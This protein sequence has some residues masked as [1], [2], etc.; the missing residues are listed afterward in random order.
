MTMAFCFGSTPEVAAFM[1]AYRLANLFRRLIGEG[2]LQS[3][4][5]PY[6]ESFQEEGSQRAVYFY[7]DTAA[8]LLLLLLM[9]VSILMGVFWGMRY[10]LTNEWGEI[11]SLAMWMAPSLI[12]ISLCSL[13]TACLNC[14]KSYFAPAVAPVF[15]NLAWIAVALAGVNLPIRNAIR[16]LAF[17]VTF[18]MAAQWIV[19]AV[20]VR[21]YISLPWSEW[22]RPQIFSA[23][24]KQL[25]RPLFLGL[26][27]VGASQI[28]GLL[29]AIFSR[30][31]DPSG[32]AF[33]W[34]AIRIQQ[35]PLAL[36]GIALA[37]ALLPSLS[38]AIQSGARE[39]YKALLVQGMRHSA[40]LMIP[41]SF[42]LF[43]LAGPGLNLL[44]GR[45][46]FLSADVRETLYCLWGYGIGLL[47]SVFILLLAT[48][49]YAKRSYGAPALAALAAMVLNGILNAIMVFYLH[50]GA[51]SIALATSVASWVNCM[52][53][54]WQLSNQIG[55]IFTSDFWISCRRLCF[56]GGFAACLALIVGAYCGDVTLYWEIPFTRNFGSQLSQFAIMGS[57]F[58]GSFVVV[59]RLMRIKDFFD[60]VR[61]RDKIREPSP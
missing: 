14:K 10:F 26:V 7:R 41:A 12:F 46:G 32:P 17:G 52:I 5:I 6:F 15:F 34:Y 36:F 50:W 51:V 21:K 8:S 20:Q 30:L 33:L 11:A 48:G 57:V 42:G 27:G 23:E 38:R 60:V 39:Q 25:I 37:G 9:I 45:G 40:A 4:F 47:S 61:W 43:V 59:A 22:I 35:L 56:A 18:A 1:V 58:I 28:N 19:T 44:Y 24:W 2:N 54:A 3:S 49:F 31:A 13:N 55:L 16:M 29:D 53:L